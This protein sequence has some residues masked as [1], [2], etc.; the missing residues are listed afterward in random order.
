[1]EDYRPTCL[2]FKISTKLKGLAIFPLKD[3]YATYCGQIRIPN[4]SCSDNQAEGQDT[5]MEKKWLIFSAS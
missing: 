2:K 3:S 1:M 4:A 5:S